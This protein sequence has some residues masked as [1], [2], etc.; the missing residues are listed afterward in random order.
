MNYDNNRGN[1]EIEVRIVSRFGVLAKYQTGWTKEINIVKWNNN[2]PKYDIRDWDPNHEKMAK[3]VTLYEGEL[4]RLV[5]IMG[6]QFGMI[7]L[8]SSGNGDEQDGIP[9]KV[10]EMANNDVRNAEPEQNELTEETQEVSE[11]DEE[12]AEDTTDDEEKPDSEEE[13]A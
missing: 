1:G 13:V 6:K 8:S 9:D 2:A 11:S 5:E 10:A 3:G 12:L 4:R 7:S